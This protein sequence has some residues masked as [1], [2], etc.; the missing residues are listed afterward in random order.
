MTYEQCKKMIEDI[1]GDE[2]D[3]AVLKFVEPVVK[4]YWNAKDVN[5]LPTA[6]K[7]KP[8]KNTNDFDKFKDSIPWSSDMFYQAANNEFG[9][10]DWFNR[11]IFRVTTGLDIAANKY[12]GDTP[13]GQAVGSKVDLV[14]DKV[15][16]I[17]ENISANLKKSLIED[18]YKSFGKMTAVMNNKDAS[19]PEKLAACYKMTNGS[20]NDINTT[21][22]H[23][24]LNELKSYYVNNGYPEYQTDKRLGLFNQYT[25]RYQNLNTLNNDLDNFDNFRKKNNVDKMSS[26]AV[27][28][29][30][31]FKDMVDDYLSMENIK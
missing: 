3:I 11:V 8:F 26:L 4:K 25:T 16:E 29:S 28:M 5:E 18:I 21:Y 22:C 9:A 24:A 14:T 10:L 19:L 23:N 7:T 30:Y 6:I 2:Y 15:N 1:S 31:L 12:F 13:L 27:T 17:G 20:L